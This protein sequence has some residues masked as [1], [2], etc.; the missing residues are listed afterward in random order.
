MTSSQILSKDKKYVCYNDS[1]IYIDMDVMYFRHRDVVYVT[2][3]G[4]H[5]SYTFF[6]IYIHLEHYFKTS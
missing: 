6:T 1:L 3:S 4:R 5:N 2:T